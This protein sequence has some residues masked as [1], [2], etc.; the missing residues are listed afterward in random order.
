MNESPR[1]NHDWSEHY[2]L[3]AKEWVALDGKARLLEET[4]TATLAKM[5]GERGDVPY[6]RAEREVKGSD[7]WHEFIT[8]MVEARTEA[9]L[10]KEKA[11]YIRMKFDEAKARA[12]AVRAEMQ[13]T[14]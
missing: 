3:A 11:A 5:I 1:I 2:R 8:R 12:F 10:A 7:A 13:M 9:N 14:R 4:K 6:N